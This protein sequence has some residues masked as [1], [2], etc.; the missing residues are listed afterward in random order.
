MRIVKGEYFKDEKNSREVELMVFED[1][2][3]HLKGI[4]LTTLSVKEKEKVLEL[5]QEFE[6][7]MK[8]FLKGFRHLKKQKLKVQS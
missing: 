8:P 5:N 3:L 4:D 2:L 1:D 6:N 7:Q